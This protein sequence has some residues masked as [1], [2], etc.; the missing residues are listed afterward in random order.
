VGREDIVMKRLA[1]VFLV[2]AAVVGLHRIRQ[3]GPCGL[4]YEPEA[5]WTHGTFHEFDTDLAPPPPPRPPKKIKHKVV[6][7][8]KVPVR[9]SSSDRLATPPAPP[10]PPVAPLPPIPP[11]S[12]KEETSLADASAELEAAPAWFLHED[13]AGSSRDA[14]RTIKGPQMATRERSENAA[15]L[16]LRKALTSWL[17]PDVPRTWSVPKPLT[18]ALILD[19][20]TES[21]AHDYGTLYVTGYRA[22]F[23]P[24]RRAA[25]VNVHHRE[26]ARKRLTLLGGAL[27]FVLVCLAS[28]STYIRADEATKGYYTNRLRMLAA[29]AVGATG[30]VLYHL[31]STRV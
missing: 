11:V 30:V 26:I 12:P 31:V 10:L 17:A 6:R 9:P 14:L 3:G 5:A 16:A 13:G 28:L 4:C 19:R 22:D 15:Q 18:N 20:H 27:G 8:K 24:T 23:S 29:G 25:V 2:V 21:V 1:L 7:V